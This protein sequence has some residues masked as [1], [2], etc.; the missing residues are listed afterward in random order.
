VLYT[1]GLTDARSPHG[2]FFGQDRFVAWLIQHHAGNPVAS[3]LSEA[4]KNEIN[5]FLGHTALSDDQTF[6]VL[7]QQ[8]SRPSAPSETAFHVADIV[9]NS[10]ASGSTSSTRRTVIP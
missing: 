2:E 9:H 5:A 10:P 6:L 8:D 3:E 4:L 7:A 1:D